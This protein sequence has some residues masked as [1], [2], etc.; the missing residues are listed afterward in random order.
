MDV[1]IRVVYELII[2]LC[3]PNKRVLMFHT[4][5]DSFSRFYHIPENETMS[6]GAMVLWTVSYMS[7]HKAVELF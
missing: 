3:R 5:V 4:T 7:N 2:S 6:D 1:H